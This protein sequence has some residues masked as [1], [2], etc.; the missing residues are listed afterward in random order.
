MALEARFGKRDSPARKMRMG[1]GNRAHATL[2]R[3]SMTLSP[4]AE[5]SRRPSP[6]FIATAVFGET[7]PETQMFRAF[8]DR[9][10]STSVCGRL[11]IALYYSV[12]PSIAHALLKHAG[13]RQIVR[14]MLLA[15]LA[16]MPPHGGEQ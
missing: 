9:H 7:A 10:L 6:C 11:F 8:R 5:S 2:L 4:H 3:E 15:L 16:R 1:D 13:A 12:S 14:S